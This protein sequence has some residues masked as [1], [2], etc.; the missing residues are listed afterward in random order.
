MGTRSRR[1]P[2]RLE[3]AAGHRVSRWSEPG[4]SASHDIQRRPSLGLGREESRGD[5][6]C[7]GEGE[8]LRAEDGLADA[9]D[10]GI[11]AA[12]LGAP[13]EHAG[14]LKMGS[15]SGVGTRRLEGLRDQDEFRT[16]AAGVNVGAQVSRAGMGPMAA[17]KQRQQF[18]FTRAGRGSSRLSWFDGCF[19]Q[20]AGNFVPGAKQEQ[21]DAGRG[22]AC[23][24]GDFAVGVALGI[25]EPKQLPVARTHLRQCRS[26]H[27]LRIGL[28][29]S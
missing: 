8:N 9:L 24:L 10:R 1:R 7:N 14:G 17:M 29:R 28:A 3:G 23:D 12:E 11:A 13:P 5:D 19:A 21:A 20:E 2:S 16:G 26:E 4:R 15:A 6:Q 25:G 18:F 27:G 22:E